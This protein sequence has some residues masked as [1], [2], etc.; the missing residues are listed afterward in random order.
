MHALPIEYNGCNV[1]I[2]NKN[3]KYDKIF[4]TLNT[5]YISSKVEVVI[6]ER[7]STIT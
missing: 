6:D 3:T 4:V 5:S 1:I 2:C 7:D